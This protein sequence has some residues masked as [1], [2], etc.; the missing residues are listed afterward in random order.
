VT[1]D[2]TDEGWTN[3][4]SMVERETAD[5]EREILDLPEDLLQVWDAGRKRF[6]EVIAPSL[7]P[8]ASGPLASPRAWAVVHRHLFTAAFLTAWQLRKGEFERRDVAAHAACTLV[9]SFGT[10]H[11][12]LRRIYARYERAWRRGLHR[13]IAG[14]SDRVGTIAMALVVIILVLV[15]VLHR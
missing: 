15:W 2:P 12:T 8:P 13:A 3:L 7:G 5:L 6:N 11:A 1:Q 4:V 10:R 14:P 9:A